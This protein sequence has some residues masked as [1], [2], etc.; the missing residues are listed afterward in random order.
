MTTSALAAKPAAR[1][2]RV[3]SVPPYATSAGAEAVELAASVGLMLDPW[4]AQIL[5]DSLGERSDGRWSAF[6]VGVIVPRQNGKGCII[7]AREL[8]G[9]FLFGER[10]IMHSAHEFKTA[11]EAFRRIRDWV[12]NTDDLRRRVKKITTSHGEEGIE[13]TSGARLRFVA[14][15]TGSGRGFSGDCVILDEAYALTSEQM[16]ALLPTLSAR[17]NPQLWFTSTPPL[18]PTAFLL[19]LRRAGLEGQDRLAY[20]DYGAD[21]NCDLDDRALW[22][23]TNPAM[24]IRIQEE[25]VAAERE[26][27]PDAEFARERLGVWPVLAAD[28]L[29]SPEEWAELA[30]PGSKTAGQLAF[31]FDVTPMRDHAAIAV[32]GLRNDGLGHAE[33]IEHRPGTDWLVNR[34]VEL[35]TKHNPVAICMDAAGPAGSFLL[36]LEKAGVLRSADPDKPRPGDLIVPTARDVAGGCGALVDAVR[37]RTVRHIDQHELNTAVGGAKTRPLGDAWAWARRAGSADISPLVAVT[38]ARWAFDQRADKVREKRDPLN[39]IW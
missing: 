3:R 7:E 31:A 17:P 21:A 16:A 10:L 5:T 22:A 6:R 28:A 4:Q 8:A 19:N 37:Q 1:L 11:A 24:G 30:D 32:F 13:L 38:L 25:F 2:P 35:K 34:L 18:D 20:F 29:I 15:S 23:A 27:L 12:D 33:L 39:N 36:P 26:T 9:L 14:R